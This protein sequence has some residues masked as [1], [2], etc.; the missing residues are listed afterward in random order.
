MKKILMT[1][2]AVAVATTMNA[3]IW[4]G[5][6]LGFSTKHNNGAEGNEKTFTVAPEIGYNLD[7]NFA[8]A[9]KFGYA[10]T[11]PN[12][13]GEITNKWSINPYVRYTFV[14][15]GNF[16]AFVDGGV[17]WSTEHAQ[18]DKKNENAFGININPGIAY[19]VSDKVTLAAHFGEGLYYKHNWKADYVENDVVVAAGHRSNEFGLNLLNGVSFSA[20]YNF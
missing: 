18:G 13:Y 4:A 11:N 5:G 10:H 12:K 9:I 16:S 6:E 19:N 15:A 14:K 7:D 3:Q 2:A 17:N 1:L 20:Y 8:V